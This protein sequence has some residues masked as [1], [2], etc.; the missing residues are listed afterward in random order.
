MGRSLAAHCLECKDTKNV[1]KRCQ[2]DDTAD[3]N[4]YEQVSRGAR[5]RERPF[6]N[7]HLAR[8]KLTD[9]FS[10]TYYM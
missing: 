6:A 9:A 2:Q 3:L 8:T 5:G 1:I 10:G 4:Q 7:V